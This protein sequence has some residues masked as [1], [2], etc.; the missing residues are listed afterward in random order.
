[1]SD[2]NQALQAIHEEDSAHDE[3]NSGVKEVVNE[4]SAEYDERAS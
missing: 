2:E 3:I 1:M 4:T